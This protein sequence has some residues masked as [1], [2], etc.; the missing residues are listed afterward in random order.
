MR[1]SHGRLARAGLAAV[2][3]VGGVLGTASSAFATDCGSLQA[4]LTAASS[5]ATVT[6]D[7]GSVCTGPYS[8]PNVPI[9]LQGGGTGATIQGA[10]GARALSGTDVG[11]TTVANLTFS[12]GGG[13]GGGGAV[14]VTGSS[15]PTFLRDTF[16]A[17]ATTGGPGGALYIASDAGSGS[18]T[19]DSS[20]FGDGSVSDRNHSTAGGGGLAISSPRNVTI[21]NSSFEYNLTDDGGG[22][23]ALVTLS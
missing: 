4:A 8:L 6:L 7:Q 21:T 16:L 19:I 15:T 23:G 13:A 9:T 18:V 5:G 17:N 3:A 2:F 14:T 10:A 22:G 11:S 20:K 1:A 12:Q